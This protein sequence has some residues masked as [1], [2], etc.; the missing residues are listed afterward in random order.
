VFRLLPRYVWHC[1]TCA[2]RG[3]LSSALNW[4][5]IVGVGAVA[6]YFQSQGLTMTDPHAWQ[7]VVKWGLIYTAV[8]WLIIFA[9]RAIF[10][11]PFQAYAR[12]CELEDRLRPKL[13]ISFVKGTTVPR[14]DGFRHTFLQVINK[15]DGF[16]E[17]VLPRIIES[18]FKREGSDF[19]QS[20]SII[21]TINLSWCLIPEENRTEKY[22]ASVLRP[23]PPELVDF[24]SGPHTKEKN[25]PA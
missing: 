18:K 11:A 20:T 5:S 15:S 7:E 21:A 19:W 1:L 3:S 12:G 2:W 8:A 25:T 23:D 10:V 6:A 22:S 16:I 17:D 13:G 14:P 9:V 4:A 24:I